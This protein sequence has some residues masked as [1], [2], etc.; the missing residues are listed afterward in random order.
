MKQIYW[1]NLFTTLLFLSYPS[2]I[3]S[4]QTD[5][6]DNNTLII[7]SIHKN[8][9]VGQHISYYVDTS[10][11]LTVSDFAEFDSLWKINKKQRLSF[12]PE[13]AHHW[14]QFKVK[15][16]LSE[17]VPIV[18]NYE[19]A[20]VAEFSIYRMERD[21]II[22][23]GTYGDNYPFDNRKINHPHFLIFDQLD[24]EDTAT[25]LLKINQEG[26]DLPVPLFISSQYHFF[27]D[28]H[29]TRLIHGFSFGLTLLIAL[30][31][32]GLFV[33]LK[34]QYFLLQFIASLFS[35][36]YV[37]AEEGYGYMYL[38]GF[39]PR[40][41]GISRPFS[42]GIVVIFSLL[43]TSSFLKF[44]H[45]NYLK[46][47]ILI[48]LLYM[49]FA[50]PIFLLPI[51]TDKTIG[52]LISI[53]LLMALFIA[54]LNIGIC[55]QKM[56]VEK[57][58]DAVFLLTIFVLPVIGILLRTISF[59][60]GIANL[61]TKHTGIIILTL[62]TTLLGGYLLYRSISIIRENQNI[63]LTLAEERQQASDSILHSLHQERERISMNIHD[64]LSSLLSAAKI[65]LETLK[66]S[67]TELK[68]NKE[69]VTTNV[70]L[71]KVSN[72]MA[73][74]AQNLMPKTLKEFGLIDEVKKHINLL[75]ENTDIQINL[76]Y[77]G[78]EERL[79]EKIE[80]ELFYITMEV[81]DNTIKYSKAA[82]VLIQFMK[83]DTE[84]VV[85]Y[86]DDGIGFDVHL[87][88]KGANGLANI[89]NRITLLY[90]ETDI[91]SKL[92]DGT[93]ITLNIPL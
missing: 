40:L 6:V 90:G 8:Y 30:G 60:G 5:D 52:P 12:G 26:Q 14:I 4:E 84:I 39:S 23:L 2:D 93:T 28:D 37:L 78:F 53:F 31:I 86:E 73:L 65:N 57:S 87:I 41:N 58:R 62:Q 3:W 42:L 38:W 56:F 44:K 27:E 63:K 89:R 54:L 80:L 21:S 68:N 15:N 82:T 85:I 34:N 10:K 91:H 25:Y 76:E 18:L 29:N 92:N 70:L 71:T 69:Y 35:L 81:L 48:C 36:F 32:L 11:A 19:Y 46:Y 20:H 83:Y 43:F 7:N 33:I 88:R 61:F 77:S 66:D 50:H 49:L 79:P 17:T 74:V 64:S 59:Q 9:P 75:K 72:E 47:P 67:F 51:H 16:N 45:S 55:L 13:Q 22:P 1:L 24:V